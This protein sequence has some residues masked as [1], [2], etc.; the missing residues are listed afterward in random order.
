MRK[1]KRYLCEEIS[2]YLF[3]ILK[4]KIIRCDPITNYIIL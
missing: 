2:L 3:F 1:I 4:N